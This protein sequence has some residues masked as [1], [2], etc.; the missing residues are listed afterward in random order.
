M[1][2]FEYYGIKN[3]LNILYK[4]FGDIMHK[5]KYRVVFD[6]VSYFQREKMKE[7]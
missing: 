6:C 4:I 5:T 1:A 2:I 3:E 7:T